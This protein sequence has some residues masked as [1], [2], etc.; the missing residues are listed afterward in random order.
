MTPMATDD[1]EKQFVGCGDRVVSDEAG[2]L[3]RFTR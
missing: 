1:T 2:P 3:C